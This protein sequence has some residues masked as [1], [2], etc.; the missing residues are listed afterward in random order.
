[1]RFSRTDSYEP[2]RARTP[3]PTKRRYGGLVVL[4]LYVTALGLNEWRIQRHVAEVRARQAQ[5]VDLDGDG[6]ADAPAAGLGTTTVAA[7]S[8]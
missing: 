2:T 3:A 4:V 6:V 8:R 7:V 1:M 5:V